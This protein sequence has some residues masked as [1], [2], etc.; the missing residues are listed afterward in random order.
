MSL[1]QLKMDLGET[2][3]QADAIRRQIA[4]VE[5]QE[6]ADALAPVLAAIKQHGFS[7][8]ELGL[9][10]MPAPRP[11]AA[12]K[13]ERTS[14]S[15][16]AKYRDPVSGSEWAG[17]GKTPGWMAAQLADGKSK[18]DFLINKPTA[19]TEAGEPAGAGE[20]PAGAHPDAAPP[21]DINYPLA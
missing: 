9:I 12:P 7:A 15:L 21:A 6:R 14:A 17:R 13:A 3:A 4:E 11:A 19:P 1:E 16:E 18:D 2:V 8:V 5:K 20:L 10:R